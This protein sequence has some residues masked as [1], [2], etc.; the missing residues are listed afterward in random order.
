MFLGLGL[1]FLSA[2]VYFVHYLIFRDM[3]H[4]FIY[5]IGDIGFVFLE[6]L[7]VTLIIHQLL[8]QREKQMLIKKLNMVI[9]VFFSEVG[10]N[11][12]KQIAAFD[13]RVK[14]IS[15]HLLVSNDWTNKE[16]SRLKKYLYRYDSDIA[17]SRAGLEELRNTLV[18]KRTFLVNLLENPNLLEHDS[19][20]D[21][22][23]AV[24]HLAEELSK[25]NN[26]ADLP[27]TDL[28][29]LAKDIKRSYQNLIGEW[30]DYT[31]HL[32]QSY[33]YLFSLAIRT[34]PFDKSAS[35]VIS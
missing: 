10:T 29:H 26:F 23:W 3:H 19:F 28:E 2:F 24:F 22:L 14:D 27:Q 12:L 8:V 32:K 20:T 30:I 9:G 4:I 21:T 6:V 11:L 34:N 5:L 31:E 13:K 7:L 16:F 1:I 15:N 35:V 25:R 33:P 17:I 18:T